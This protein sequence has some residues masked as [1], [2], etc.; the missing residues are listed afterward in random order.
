MLSGP[1]ERQSICQSY[2]N[3]PSSEHPN[4]VLEDFF[5]MI[6]LSVKT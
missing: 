6:R 3:R 2:R 5:Q 1:F 4:L